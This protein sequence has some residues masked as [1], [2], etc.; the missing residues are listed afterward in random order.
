ML[1]A[2]GMDSERF[3]QGFRFKTQVNESDTFI[4]ILILSTRSPVTFLLPQSSHSHIH[5][6]LMPCNNPFTSSPSN[7]I[8]PVYLLTHFHSPSSVLQIHHQPIP[9]H[10]L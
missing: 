1:K 5:P 7:L 3:Q 8:F 2:V 10:T 6:S 9:I 4:A